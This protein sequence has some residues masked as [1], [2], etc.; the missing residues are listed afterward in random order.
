[1][2]NGGGFELDENGEVPTKPLKGWNIGHVG[3]VALLLEV[4]YAETQEELE[5][6]QEHALCLAISLPLALQLSDVL[7]KYGEAFLNQSSP[8]GTQLH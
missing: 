1:M 5:T 4:H 3:G 2:N 7:R 6:G 8:A